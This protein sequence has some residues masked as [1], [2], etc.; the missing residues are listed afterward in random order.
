MEFRKAEKHAKIKFRK[1]KILGRPRV[2]N[3]KTGDLSVAIG[4]ASSITVFGQLK[5]STDAVFGVYILLW[6]HQTLKME[7]AA[8]AQK[9][10][11]LSKQPRIFHTQGSKCECTNCPSVQTTA[12]EIELVARVFANHLR[13]SNKYFCSFR[14]LAKETKNSEGVKTCSIFHVRFRD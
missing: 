9:S 11:I 12:Q 7:D 8:F 2:W 6:Y 10:C 3:R 13:L 5:P 14:L 4:I 1:K